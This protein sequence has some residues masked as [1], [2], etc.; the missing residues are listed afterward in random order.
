MG[1]GWWM[2]LAEDEQEITRSPMERVR[3]PKTPTKLIPVIRDDDTKKLP[4]AC[5]GK[6]F[7]QLRDEAIIRLLYNAGA[8]LSEVGNLTLDDGPFASAR[9][10]VRSSIYTT[11]WDATHL[12]SQS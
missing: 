7:V 5:K 10:A 3:Q 11:L 2:W 1:Y 12:G 8:R 6:R 9:H 4:E